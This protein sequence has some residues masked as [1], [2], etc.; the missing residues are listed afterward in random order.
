MQHAVEAEQYFS[1]LAY[2]ASPITAFAFCTA[3]FDNRN[4]VHR[5]KKKYRKHE[6]E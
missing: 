2:A 4:R 3:L 6:R 5:S 1:T